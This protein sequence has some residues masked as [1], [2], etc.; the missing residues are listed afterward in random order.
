[1][2]SFLSL[3]SSP[4]PSLR[5][6]KV[7]TRCFS[8]MLPNARE[9]CGLSC[10]VTFCY[11]LV[12]TRSKKAI[13]FKTMIPSTLGD[14]SINAPPCVLDLNQGSFISLRDLIAGDWSLRELGCSWLN[15]FP[16][17]PGGLPFSAEC[18]R[19][20]PG[21]FVFSGLRVTS[22]ANPACTGIASTQARKRLIL[23]LILILR[24]ATP[25]SR[26]NYL[27]TGSPKEYWRCRSIAGTEWPVEIGA[28]PDPL[29]N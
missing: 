12:T 29:M 28:P 2:V 3:T 25:I 18:V 27:R 7:A 6:R 20:G 15:V 10:D 8:H 26:G 5:L 4:N 1:V 22:I 11:Y 17:P 13:V 19:R 23:I 9:A 14:F 16:Y 21:D 24:I